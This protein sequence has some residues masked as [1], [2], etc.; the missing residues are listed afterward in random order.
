M[1]EFAE[2]ACASNNARITRWLAYATTSNNNNNNNDDNNDNNNDNSGT[3]VYNGL[4]RSAERNGT[5]G[6]CGAR[7]R[8]AIGTALAK[9]NE[10]YVRCR[11]R[12]R[13][14][15][16]RRKEGM[17]VEHDNGIVR[18]QI[19]RGTGRPA[20]PSRRGPVVQHVHPPAPGQRGRIRIALRVRN[21]GR[22]NRFQT[23]VAHTSTC[24]QPTHDTQVKLINNLN[25]CVL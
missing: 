7:A 8:V 21:P 4:R 10:R 11:S 3:F 5:D 24:A 13:T 20:R 9:Q 12:A 2:F 6:V 22:L 23:S 18:V 1:G 25:D 16:C 19:Y 17:P 14:T 15:V